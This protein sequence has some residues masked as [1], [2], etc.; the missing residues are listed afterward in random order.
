MVSTLGRRRLAAV[1]I[2]MFSVFIAAIFGAMICLILVEMVDEMRSSR[3]KLT[4]R[5]HE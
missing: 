3:H 4:D 1:E 2:T 5:Y